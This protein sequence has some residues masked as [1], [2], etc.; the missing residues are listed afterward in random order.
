MT[1]QGLPRWF[2]VASSLALLALASPL[3]AVAAVAVAVT[4]GR[5]VLFRQQRV[6][7]DGRLFTLLKFRTMP[8]GSGGLAETL[9]Q[10][11]RITPV[12]RWLRKLKIDELPELWNVVRGDM[13]LVGPRPE[14]PEYVDATSA[15]WRDVLK[16]RPGITDPVTLRL[17]NEE[18]LLVKS[19]VDRER[20]YRLQLQPYK[21][22]GYRDY[23]AVRTAGT[24]LRVLWRTAIGVAMPNVVN[25]PSGE[26]LVRRPSIP[27]A[28]QR[29]RA[30]TLVTRGA[31]RRGLWISLVD[32]AL[33]VVSNYAAFWLRFDGNVPA[34]ETRLWT[35]TIWALVA[36]RAAAFLVFGVARNVWRYTSVADLRA[37]ILGVISSSVIFYAIIHGALGITMYPRSTFLIDAFVLITLIG[38]VRLAYRLAPN[39]RPVRRDRRVLILGAGDAAESIL[40]EMQVSPYHRY[41]PIGL[42]EADRSQVGRRIHGVAVVG[43]L[44]DLP[45]I[46]VEHD[47]DEVIVAL[48]AARQA[49]FNRIMDVLARFNAVVSTVPYVNGRPK[50]T[51][52]LGEIRRV[53]LED[54]LG[55]ASEGVLAPDL[56]LALSGLRVLVTGAAGPVGTEVCRQLLGTAASITLFDRNER[57]L[58]RVMDSIAG[59]KGAESVRPVIGELTD[60]TVLDG[61]FAGEPPDVVIHGAGYRN[62][63][64]LTYNVCEAIRHNIGGTR[65]L[66]DAARRA[67]VRA[68]LLL[69]GAEAVEQTT[70][71]G[72]TLWLDEMVM[73]IAGLRGPTHFAA[74][75]LGSVLS[76]DEGL[77]KQYA[78]DLAAGRDV[79]VGHASAER[80]F[81]LPADAAQLA[82]RTVTGLS[83]S[84][85]FASSDRPLS[86]IELARTLVRLAGLTPDEDVQ[87]ITAG[88]EPGDRPGASL[89]GAHETAVESPVAGTLLIRA[90]DLDLPVLAAQIE[91]LEAAASVGDA[92]LVADLLGALVPGVNGKAVARHVPAA[93]ARARTAVT[94]DAASPAAQRRGA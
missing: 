90:A 1:S 92:G 18:S 87:F 16:A 69:S 83:A 50:P 39:R 10:R 2:E 9:R 15:L 38:G 25:S 13:S 6:G 42:V 63:S 28:R 73:R 48:P 32:A 17:R 4:T 66:A 20:F 45:S 60:T 49:E 75:R 71:V 41:L 58:A 40:R 7:R 80:V 36:I 61:L 30:S 88:V 23:L 24:D 59:L 31:A 68:F 91:D 89:V 21:L 43:T 12:G 82:L 46:M 54:L 79:S 76:Y 35:Q 5:P 93:P 8:V 72:A 11:N 78:D 85:V 29:P 27:A 57:G 94:R 62:E 81:T 14:V 70:L 67:S 34:D 53:A 19:G 55:R 64:L 44:G 84:G 51:L 22:R 74:L 56:R 65:A 33:V 86:E 52:A 3:L 77:L 26:K 37:I 47:P